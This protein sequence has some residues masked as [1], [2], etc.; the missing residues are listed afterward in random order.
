M[1]GSNVGVGIEAVLKEG[2]S[3]TNNFVHGTM[4]SLLSPDTSSSSFLLQRVRPD[5]VHTHTHIHYRKPGLWYHPARPCFRLPRHGAGGEQHHRRVGRHAQRPQQG[6]A[7]FSSGNFFLSSFSFPLLFSR[8]DLASP[9]PTC[10][11]MGSNTTRPRHLQFRARDLVQQHHRRYP[12]PP[13]KDYF[14]S[15]SCRHKSS[16]RGT[17]RAGSGQWGIMLS[18]EPDACPTTCNIYGS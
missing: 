11:M 9:A 8:L 1:Q 12:R 13:P 2:S 16:H 3:I 6:Y 14:T 10:G 18:R 17:K 4:T 5:W 7:T 15:P